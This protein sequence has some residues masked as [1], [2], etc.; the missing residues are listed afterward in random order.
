ML[1]HWD[2]ASMVLYF[3]EMARTRGGKTPPVAP[4]RVY[5]T[6]LGVKVR[7]VHGGY[8]CQ[9]PSL[10]ISSYLALDRFH[11]RAGQP[12][13]WLYEEVQKFLD[14]LLD[15]VEDRLLGLDDTGIL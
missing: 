5:M 7:K 2:R 15:Q 1:L 9:P 4:A 3:V 10:K 13:S 12:R 8:V 11:T 6:P 14:H